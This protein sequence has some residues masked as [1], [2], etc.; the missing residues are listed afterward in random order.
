MV[1]TR[2]AVASKAS[3][4]DGEVRA[5]RKLRERH[6]G[7]K[8]SL[9][10]GAADQART[11]GISLVRTGMKRRAETDPAPSLPASKRR[12]TRDQQQDTAVVSFSSGLT[13]KRKSAESAVAGD[14]EFLEETIRQLKRV[15]VPSTTSRKTDIRWMLPYLEKLEA[16]SPKRIL[17]QARQPGQPSGDAVEAYKLTPREAK[18]LLQNQIEV[19]VPVF[20]A[21]GTMEI[22]DPESDRRPIEQ[23]LDW[24]PD[25]DEEHDTFDLRAGLQ[26]DGSL[27]HKDVTTSE[28]RERFLNNQKQP[29]YPWNCPD[30][31]FPMPPTIPGFLRHPSCSLLHHIV[32]HVQD[33]SDDKIC[34][35]TCKHHG[36]TAIKCPEHFMTPEELVALQ[37]GTRNWHGTIMLAEPGALTQTRTYTDG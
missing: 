23:I 14:T 12:R 35:A 27:A 7:S 20:V 5:E 24:F 30:I 36:A 18:R 1:S 21:G 16:V 17:H 10:G 11:G 4:L 19:D 29:L 26:E 32:R 37:Q 25:P 34:P 9:R 33:V 6:N 28:L 31:P 3:P 13:K 22:L 8:G 15:K 2:S